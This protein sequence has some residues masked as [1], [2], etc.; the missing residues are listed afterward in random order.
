MKRSLLF[1]F[2]LPFSLFSQPTLQQKIRSLISAGTPPDL[3]LYNYNAND[4]SR[5]QSGAL[6]DWAPYLDADQAWKERFRA[7][8]LAAVT[9]DGQVVGIPSDQ[10]PV[11]FYYHKDLLD[12]A[13]V[14]SFPTT[15]DELFAAADA[16]KATGVAPFA[17]MTAD[18]AWHSMNAFTYL[19]AS[20]GGPDV[21]KPGSSLD[22]PQ[23]VEAATN[24]QRL[25][26]YTTPDAVG[27]NYSVSTQ[28]FLSG[29]AAIII[30]GPWLISSIQDQVTDPCSVQVAAGPASA[31]GALPAGFAVTD[32]VNYW[33]AAKSADQAKADATAEWMRSFTSEDSARRMSVEGAFPL[34][35]RTTLTE[36]DLAS[37]NCQ[38][39]SVLRLSNDA[40]AAVVSAVRDL[41]PATQAQLPALLEEL[42]LGSMTPEDFV[43][44]LEAANQ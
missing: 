30:D 2:L 20:I 43:A 38:M 28:N 40:P 42:A 11:F 17:L 21:F 16:I 32:S 6:L 44:Q 29:R 5:E 14:T 8:N 37:A 22:T 3:F 31:S 24:L 35:V 27:A 19:A 39:A 18:D 36:G 15:W 7:E 34:A 23:L 13:G 41:K 9:V 25:F 4:L 26:G 1:L 12:A 10:A 33:A